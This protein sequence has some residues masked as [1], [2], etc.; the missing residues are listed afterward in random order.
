MHRRFRI[1]P[2]AAKPL[3]FTLSNQ[4]V[5]QMSSYQR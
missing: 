4:G 1:F 3:S 5:R 2:F